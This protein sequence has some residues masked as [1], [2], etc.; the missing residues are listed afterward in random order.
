MGNLNV[1]MYHYVRDLKNSRYPSI[2]GLDVDLFEEQLDFF[3]SNYQ[4]VT[5]EQVMDAK[6]GK[7]KLPER[8]LLL[9]FD[10]GY[11][12]HYQFV[13]PKLMERG[14]QGS[15]FVSASV[16][17][18]HRLLDV[19]KTHFILATASVDQIM[20]DLLDKMDEYRGVE[21]DYPSN[22]ELYKIFAK[23]NRFDP[24][25]VIFIKRMLQTALP[26]KLRGRIASELFEKYVGVSEDIFAR[27]L[28]MSH[29]QLKMMKKCGMYIGIHGYEHYWMS[30]IS[31]DE[32][33]RDIVK[34]LEIMKDFVDRN[35][36]V[37]NYPYGSYDDW[38]IDVVKPMG[39]IMGLGVKP[40]VYHMGEH[41]A[42]EI[43]RFD[44]ND[45]PPKSNNYL[46][47]EG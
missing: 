22:D 25:E 7:A 3:A 24:P 23:A 13:L 30:H 45:F 12:D 39:C 20:R 4:F 41:N 35:R 5:M 11:M 26:E 14:I 9:T 29:D 17:T 1:I 43:S 33:E 21:F 38:I 6:E 28:Y 42:F 32:L 19:N 8:A 46:T 2:K 27:E 40:G 15:F 31:R 18:E 34:A 44:C 36:W 37:I 10:D 47:Y 16:F